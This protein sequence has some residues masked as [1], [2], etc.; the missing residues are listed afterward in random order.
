MYDFSFLAP[1]P[2]SGLVI[3]GT[4]DR[5]APPKDTST[6][7]SKLHEQKGITITHEQVEG[8]GHFFEEP[9]M[10]TMISTVSSY[11]KRRLG[12]ASR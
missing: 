1:C 6:L 8:A 2:A 7:V 3:N 4:A 9:H 5:V 11:V 12:E 10:D